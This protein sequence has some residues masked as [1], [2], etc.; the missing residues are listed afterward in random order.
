MV[1]LQPGVQITPLLLKLLV[2]LWKDATCV[3]AAWVIS[4]VNASADL[5]EAPLIDVLESP[6]HAANQVPNTAP[7][8][9]R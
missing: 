5:D 4:D 1:G 6:R 3:R 9:R 7:I 8:G 2:D